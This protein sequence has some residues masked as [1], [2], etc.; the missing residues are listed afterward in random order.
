[1]DEWVGLGKGAAQETNGR[2]YFLTQMAFPLN[3]QSAAIE[4]NEKKEKETSLAH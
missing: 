4:A 2:F 1:M 3:N